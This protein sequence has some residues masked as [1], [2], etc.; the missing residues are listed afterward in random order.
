VFREATQ[1]AP[2]PGALIARLAP[3]AIIALSAVLLLWSRLLPLSQSLWSD[4]AYTY[5]NYIHPGPGGI[6]GTYIPNDHMLFE[7]L[8]WITTNVLGDS[9]E[10]VLRFWS[11]IPAIAAGVLMT[12]W[13]WRRLGRWVAAIFA[14]LAAAAPLYMTLSVEARGY[15]IAYLA[16]AVMVITADAFLWKHRRRDLILFAAS[17]TAGI[18]TLPVFVLAFL[19]LVGLMMTRK[20]LRRNA[21][22]ALLGVGLASLVW[23][24]PVLHGVA[25]SS[26]QQFGER[27]PWYGVVSFPLKDLI[28]PSV[29]LLM[30]SASVTATELIG[31]VIVAAGV[32]VLWRVPERYLALVLVT[33]ALFAYL[34][35]EV[36]RFY[37]A[38]RF[39]SF[40]ELPLLVLCAVAIVWVGRR[41]ATIP[42]GAALAVA[43]AFAFAVF[44]LGKAEDTFSA[45]IET[46]IEN[47]KEVAQLTKS[48]GIQAVVT[49]STK[50]EGFFDY[51]GFS[52]VHTMNPAELKPLFCSNV[53]PFV[54]IEHGRSP[55]ADTTCL[56]QRGAVFVRVPQTRS[57]INVWFVRGIVSAGGAPLAGPASPV[58][59]ERSPRPGN[60]TCPSVIET[61][62]AVAVPS[63]ASAVGQPFDLHLKNAITN[64]PYTVR[65]T[66]RRV[67]LIPAVRGRFSAEGTTFRTHGKF[68][69]IVY[70]I[71]NLGPVSVVKPEETV[72]MAMA[73]DTHGHGVI[74]SVA[75]YDKYCGITSA[76]YAVDTGA[77]TT[78]F[79]L[80]P[81]KSITTVGLYP[82][83]ELVSTP[84]ALKGWAWIDSANGVA[85][86][87]P[88]PSV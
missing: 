67:L 25:T 64:R 82:V 37:E 36:G 79:H 31:G 17:A 11:A 18:W 21:T 57:Y 16:A 7:L 22:L 24:A 61:P 86:V 26:G 46:P 76:S 71:T 42:G 80:A 51:L 81:G 15:G 29:A 74:M 65:V 83:P 69:A 3:A 1:S 66:V 50:A 9:T 54:Y 2:A 5:I 32:A 27:L 75:T 78:Y 58:L 85:A 4:E 84:A 38:N 45:A 62:A 70:R 56:R 59:A 20:P 28:S 73:L 6:W 48:S 77:Q 63:R 8:E 60:Q 53:A 55:L 47:F 87:L 39:V 33:P 19:P 88:N 23:Y 44:T 10:P 40:V 13:L 34:F 35:L 41:L 52:R 14:L 72:N 12:A 68:L 43:G 30:P 49:N